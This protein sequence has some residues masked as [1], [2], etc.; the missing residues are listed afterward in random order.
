MTRA[1]FRLPA[2]T[3]FAHERRVRCHGN[4]TRR[5]AHGFRRLR[6]ARR[7]SREWRTTFK[8]VFDNAAVQSYR[9][10]A[11]DPTNPKVGVAA[12]A[13]KLGAQ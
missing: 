4:Q 2:R 11:F 8:P 6:Q 3:P 7:L 10:V 1:R 12:P 5:P 13:E 9:A